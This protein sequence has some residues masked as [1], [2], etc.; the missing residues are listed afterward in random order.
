MSRAAPILFCTNESRICQEV[1]IGVAVR[2]QA[3]AAS[4][5]AMIHWAEAGILNMH[6]HLSTINLRTGFNG[7]V[8]FGQCNWYDFA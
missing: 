2:I 7:T 4:T 8:K 5:P 1:G 6:E 3:T